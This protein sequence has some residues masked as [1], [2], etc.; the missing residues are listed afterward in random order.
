MPVVATKNHV[1][2]A[3]ADIPIV[4]LDH[5]NLMSLNVH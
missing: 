1:N 2:S 5:L 3:H 4:V